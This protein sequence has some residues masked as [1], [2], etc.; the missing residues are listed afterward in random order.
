MKKFRNIKASILIANYN[1]EKYIDQCI[2]SAINQTY[3]NIEVIIHDDNSSDG[4]IKKIKKYKKI[5]LIKNN[6][7]T[8]YGSINQLNA[9]SRA[10]KK[11]TGDIIFFLDSDDYFSKFK[12]QK[13]IDYYKKNPKI[14]SLYDLPIYKYNKNLKKKSKKKNNFFFN[15]WS[16]I[17]NQSCLSLRRQKVKKIL[18]QVKSGFFPDI[19]IDFRIGVY[20]KNIINDF[21]IIEKNL[22]YYR[23]TNQMA[24]KKFVHLSENWWQRRQQAHMYVQH[25]FKKNKMKYRSSFDY[26]ITKMINKFYLK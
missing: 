2:Q 24:S 23:Q 1:N 9:Y 19:W 13:M 3:Q 14:N 10:F 18:N 8:N 16:Y 5:K 21:T 7:R 15:H 4:S 11:S 20:L 17:P 6:N 22:T 12:V 25:L 26:F